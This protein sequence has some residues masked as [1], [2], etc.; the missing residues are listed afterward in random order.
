MVVTMVMVTAYCYGRGMHTCPGKTGP[1][2]RKS[3]TGGDSAALRYRPTRKKGL[4][5]LRFAPGGVGKRAE[6]PVSAGLCGM[7]ATW[8]VRTLVCT[9]FAGLHP[10]QTKNGQDRKPNAGAGLQPILWLGCRNR[11]TSLCARSDASDTAPRNSL[12]ACA[13]ARLTESYDNLC[14]MRQTGCKG[15]WADFCN[16]ASESPANPRQH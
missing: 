7:A 3:N 16:P 2:C 15:S 12:Y 6:S 11:P 5:G 14:P 13:C 4:Q 10:G 1:S 9:R 8:K